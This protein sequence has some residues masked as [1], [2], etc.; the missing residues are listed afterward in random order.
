M[1]ERRLNRQAAKSAK[2]AKD[3]MISSR[4]D[5]ELATGPYAQRQLNLLPSSTNRKIPLAPLGDL[6][7]LAVSEKRDS[8][9]P[10]RRLA[11]AAVAC[12]AAY[13]DSLLV[14]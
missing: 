7:A 3:F 11:A 9:T 13:W 8:S 10:P 14:P 5:L 2:Y 1:L 12:L 4:A 6:G